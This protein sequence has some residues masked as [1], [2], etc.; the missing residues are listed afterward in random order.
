MLSPAVERRKKRKQQDKMSADLVVCT[1]LE[2]VVYGV[3]VTTTEILAHQLEAGEIEIEADGA[4]LQ[5][6]IAGPAPVEVVV[7]D[8]M[9][10]EAMEAEV[11]LEQATSVVVVKVDRHSIPSNVV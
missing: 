10:L 7:V 1:K 8:P 9:A 6:E 11:G 2:G 3:A 5:L 4:H